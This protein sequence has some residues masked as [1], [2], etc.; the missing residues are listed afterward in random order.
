MSDDHAPLVML[1]TA[2]NNVEA[3]GAL[4]SELAPDVPA[5][6]VLRDDLLHEAFAAGELNDDIRRRSAEALRAEARGGAALV[7]C[8]CSTIGPGADD[9]DATSEA[10]GLA[11]VL[12]VD[13][14]MAE[15]AVAEHRRIGVAA[16]FET[17]L[18]PTMDLIAEAAARA[19]R[20]VELVPCLFSQGRARFEAGDLEGYLEV[21]ADGLRQAA[22]NTDVIVLAQASMAPALARAGGLPV[23]VLSSPRSG[24]ETALDLWR[25]EIAL[26]Y[27]RPLAGRDLPPFVFNRQ[28]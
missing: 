13:R 20:D 4:L 10:E 6:H 24:L 17:T 7:L 22:Q 21:I 8:T 5:R 15:L 25:R 28:K 14:P 26:R 11:P 1:H 27:E 9:A 18:K 19:G 23:A 2:Q 3:F 12:R 16:T